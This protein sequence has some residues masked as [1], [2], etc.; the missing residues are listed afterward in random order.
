MTVPIS[1]AAFLRG[2]IDGEVPPVRP[3]WAI[4]EKDFV[5]QCSSCLDCVKA[6]PEGIIEIGRGDLPVVSFAGGGCTFCAACVEACPDGV[7]GP[8]MAE[9]GKALDGWSH[10]VQASGVCVSTKGVFCGI[11]A[12]QCETRAI[13]FPGP[14]GIGEPKI[15]LENCTGCGACIEPCPVDAL[16]PSKHDGAQAPLKEKQVN[17]CGVLIQ[18]RPEKCETVG[19]A[20]AA[21]DGLEVHHRENDGRIV[22]T[23]EDT[24]NNYA[25]KTLTDIH[26]IE[27]VIAASLV[28]HQYDT[29]PLPKEEQS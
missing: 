6:C 13:T 22:V 2:N 3:P 11:C 15:D 9:D 25:S 14:G 12:E 7:L 10:V 5:E 8:A 28:Y 16:A 18:A 1:R 19:A 20:L 29:E 24:E 23:I 21:F 17:I 26:K 27:G 4:N